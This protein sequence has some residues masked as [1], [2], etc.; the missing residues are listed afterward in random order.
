MHA[1]KKNQIISLGLFFANIVKWPE[2]LSQMAITCQS[3]YF[4]PNE[5]LIIAILYII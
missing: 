3:P 2:Q 4:S 1:L 5:S